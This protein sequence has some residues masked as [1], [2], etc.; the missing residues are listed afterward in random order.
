M[1]DLIMFMVMIMVIRLVESDYYQASDRW[2]LLHPSFLL[3]KLT[4]NLDPI[5][6]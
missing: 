4:S 5:D 1:P 3:A 6:F 2:S